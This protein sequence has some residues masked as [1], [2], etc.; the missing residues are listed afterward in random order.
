MNRERFA[1]HAPQ[2]AFLDFDLSLIVVSLILCSSESRNALLPGRRPWMGD[3]VAVADGHKVV[4]QG[5]AGESVAYGDCFEE[6]LVVG[7]EGR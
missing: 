4:G 3:A 7:W 1:K 5:S 2:I 6:R